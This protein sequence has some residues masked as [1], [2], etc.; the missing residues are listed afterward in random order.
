M[1]ALKKFTV[2]AMAAWATFAAPQ[3]GAVGL[4]GDTLTFD[5]GYPTP[6]TPYWANPTQTTTVVAGDA[7]L[8]DWSTDGFHMTV[9]PE[10]TTIRF[11]L[12]TP[13][14]FVGIP[15]VFDGFRITGFGHDI[16]AVSLTDNT[17]NL[18]VAIDF[19]PRV[20]DLNLLGANS[21]NGGFTLNVA[22]V[23]EPASAALLLAGLLG[24]AGV[25]ARRR[26][27]H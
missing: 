15:S 8:I 16:T 21:A 23:P 12:I 24:V 3:A 5:R 11:T 25:A 20:I 18:S 27:S 26:R 17:S 10:A 6:D 19:G 13:S 22:V 4:I 2:V 7:D 14:T 1:I 9:D